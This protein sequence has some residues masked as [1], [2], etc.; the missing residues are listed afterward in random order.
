MVVE[1]INNTRKEVYRRKS[2]SLRRGIVILMYSFFLLAFAGF[3]LATL[4]ELP[5]ELSD[6]SRNDME[7]TTI[8]NATVGEVVKLHGTIESTRTFFIS[9]KDLGRNKYVSVS[10]SYLNDSS[11]RV[12]LIVPS[13]G[14]ELFVDIYDSKSYLNGEKAYIIGKFSNETGVPTIRVDAISRYSDSFFDSRDRA[15]A[16]FLVW[17]LVAIILFGAL[18]SSGF[19]R[20]YYCVSPQWILSKQKM[21]DEYVYLTIS[22]MFV[23][24]FTGYIYFYVLEPLY[25]FIPVLFLIN[26]VIFSFLYLMSRDKEP[27]GYNHQ[28]FIFVE[29]RNHEKYKEMGK[30]MIA[31]LDRERLEHKGFDAERLSISLTNHELDIQLIKPSHK[32]GGIHIEIGP[33]TKEKEFTVAKKLKYL[34]DKEFDDEKWLDGKY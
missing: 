6:K 2:R 14:D 33:I 17:S 9:G 5:A 19:F 29:N 34:L 23:V 18:T 27:K 28:R 12:L 22:M 8:E 13:D 10:E 11:G 25:L 1:D 20:I 4:Y 24:P 26:A 21:E 32:L 16:H 31:I 3:F 7:L 15:F 30:A